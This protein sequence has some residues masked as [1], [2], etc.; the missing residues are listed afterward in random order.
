MRRRIRRRVGRTL[1]LVAVAFSMI[2]TTLAGAAPL[3]VADEDEEQE[4]APLRSARIDATTPLV[5][6]FD[7][8]GSMSDTTADGEVKMAAAKQVMSDVLADGRMKTALWTYPGGN[9][10][11][12]C[13]AGAWVRGSG[14][15]DNADATRVAA[16]IRALVPDGGTPTGPALRAV[17]DA[18]GRGTDAEIILIS[19]GESNCGENPCDVAKEL[20]NEGY[21]IRVQP[22]GF[23]L[24]ENPGNEL[25]CIAEATGGQYHEAEDA[26][27]L[28]DYIDSTRVNPLE[29]TVEAPKIAQTESVLTITATLKNNMPERELTD[30][31]ANLALSTSEATV[32]RFQA[33][34]KPL[35]VI[36]PESSAKVSWDISLTELPDTIEWKVVAG[37]AGVE[38]Q[39]VTGAVDVN[40][41]SYTYQDGGELLKSI[42]GKV[43]VMG[44]SFSSGEGNQPPNGGYDE[45]GEGWADACHRKSDSIY[46]AYLYE[47]DREIANIACSGAITENFNSAQEVAR[48]RADKN[49]KTD[50]VKVDPQLD[51]LLRHR[52]AEAVFL[53]IGGNDVGFGDIVRDCVMPGKT[54]AIE[55]FPDGSIK[56]SSITRAYETMKELYHPA[57]Y[58][59]QRE[60][61]FG[62]GAYG[63]LPGVYQKIHQTVNAGKQPGEPFAPIIVSAYPMPVHSARYGGCLNLDSD[64][65]ASMWHFIQSLNM[66]IAEA[67]KFTRENYHIPV[68]FAENIEDMAQP[69][70]HMCG[71]AEY[72]YFVPITFEE[73]AW[74]T[75]V[76]KIA[77]AMSLQELVHPNAKGH[78]KWAQDL[79][80]WSSG[81]D[82]L[83]AGTDTIEDPSR[84]SHRLWRGWRHLPPV[85][86]TDAE[87]TYDLYPVDGPTPFVDKQRK[88]ALTLGQKITIHLT[89]L[90]PLASGT[91]IMRSEP[92]MLGSAIADEN[93]DLTMTVTVPETVSV[94]Q[95]HLEIWSTDEEGESVAVSIPVTVY[96]P[97][98]LFIALIAVFSLAALAV[99]IVFMVIARKRRRQH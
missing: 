49:A 9:D 99:A 59:A 1:G 96:P 95:H 22:V 82:N 43:V 60:E 98:P 53:T 63:T 46:P 88:K 6:V 20:I 77:G 76:D 56:P 93:G 17:A 3:S 71:P 58:S 90:A 38:A 5:I 61:E 84:L 11:D 55:H 37:A 13:P 54:C 45:P 2:A 80:V 67:V 89:R 21:R 47:G 34:Q 65:V 72:S 33:L 26:Q 8:S 92:I 74:R 78:Q 91:L 27:Q 51:Q 62:A 52:D 10:V 39:I 23:D 24:G 57:K 75:A 4:S 14:W 16:D 40:A 36:R 97:I 44:D 86:Y 19:D 69:G 73:G 7:T 29:L 18:I 42:S 70:H 32:S 94:G 31:K 87:E 81:K 41:D 50:R 85:I 64:E 30:V 79:I 25:E 68:Y 35:P 48:G 15:A 12:G 66:T 83:T 28:K